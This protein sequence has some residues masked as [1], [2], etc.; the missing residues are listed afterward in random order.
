MSHVILTRV[1]QGRYSYPK[2]TTE[3]SEAQVIRIVQ[4]P[5]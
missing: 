5:E 3:E 2:F 4:G 1:L